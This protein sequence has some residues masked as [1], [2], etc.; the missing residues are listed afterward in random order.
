MA[1]SSSSTTPTLP[2]WALI[3]RFIFRTDSSS[4]PADDPTEASSTNSR[5]DA[6]RVCFQFHAPPRPSVVH[7]S[8]P[9]GTG[10]RD[11]FDVVAAHRDAVLLQM[12]YPIPVPR[13]EYPYDMYD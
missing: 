10:D 11:R 4:F 6:I 5:G 12:A 7:L 13:R 2:D 9:A 1:S 3:D 8:W